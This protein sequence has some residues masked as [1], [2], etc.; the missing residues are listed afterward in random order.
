MHRRQPSARTILSVLG[1]A[2]FFA[3]TVGWR[4]TLLNQSFALQAQILSALRAN[5]DL[6]RGQL[7][8]EAV[9]RNAGGAGF[10][11]DLAT[12]RASVEHAGAHDAEPSLD[13]LAAARAAR[14]QGRIT[15]QAFLGR[16][17]AASAGVRSAVEERSNEAAGR[18]RLGFVEL[19]LA[20]FVFGSLIAWLLIVE[21]RRRLKV[22][23]QLE[24]EH[25]IIEMIPQM[26][27][28]KD[29]NGRN[30]YCNTR[31]LEYMNITL[32]EFMNNSWMVAHPDDVAR[33]QAVWRASVAAGT[34]YESE[35]RLAPK[36]SAVYRWFLVRAVPFRDATGRVVK[37]Y[38]TTTDID[39]QRRAMAAM[40]FLAQSGAQL[41]GAE[42]AATVLDRLAHAS[43]D[44]LAD[45]SI[46]DLE[47]EDGS[48][49]RLVLAATHI[50]PDVVAATGKFGA[51]QPGEPHP[52]ARAMVSGETIHVPNIDDAFIERSVTPAERRDAWRFVDIRSMVCVPMLVPGRAIGAL[53]LLR[54]G[55]SAP[56]EAS[57]VKVVE[58]VARR[59]AVAIENIRLRER[60]QAAARDLQTFV[61][62]SESI[63]GSEGLQE[64]I[65][66]ALAVLVPVRAA[67]AFVLLADENGALAEPASHATPAGGDVLSV[68]FDAGAVRGAL[69][70]HAGDSARFT[71]GDAA[72]FQ[73]FA[74]R[75]APAI[76]HAKLFE[77][78]RNVAR[79]FQAAALPASLPDVPGFT[80][81]AMYEAGKAEALVGGDWY[82]A[83]A[84]ADG[85]IVVSV[86]DVAGSGL[87]A[88]VT[89]AGVR[90][91]IRGAAHVR[92]DPGVMLDAAQA[93]LAGERFVTAFVGVIDPRTSTLAYRSAGHPPPLLLRPGGAIDELAIGGAPLG[94]DFSTERAEHVLTLPAASLLVLY[95]DGLI[96]STHDVIDG[97]HRLRDALL[98]PTIAQAGDPARALHDRVLVH[99]S[100]DDVAI[101]TIRRA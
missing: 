35:L 37:W 12:L 13:V 17:E 85:R 99:G 43:L 67:G 27:W 63:S 61:D 20:M 46:F 48:F 18:T 45:I 19:T 2:A 65:D 72:F 5:D 38:G 30:D 92:A 69:R 47:Q 41:A 8:E 90:Q 25:T 49:R 89:M 75:L 52:I 11:H 83:F 29:E 54:V 76:A 16:V 10:E 95:S 6:L 77:R 57:E 101:L 87:S 82:D 26:V 31:F 15:E 40:D 22:V 59:A 39:A 56:F 7:R 70:L 55:R 94:V 42:D 96:E 4:L 62:L 100:R 3:V 14:L 34:A 9:G 1:I 97:M 51:P 44:G 21:P 68:D 60:E 79:S 50:A 86:G 58:E 84:L 71:P 53:T 36:G 33:G 32:D 24:A 98:D 81:R 80:F 78:D 93:V 73:E 64:T 66:A 23:A 88:A 28:T 74:R 91:A